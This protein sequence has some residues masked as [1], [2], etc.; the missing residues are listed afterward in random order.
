TIALTVII[1][2][3]VFNAFDVSKNGPDTSLN[4]MDRIYIRGL[5]AMVYY[6]YSDKEKFEEFDKVIS[7]SILVSYYNPYSNDT[8]DFEPAYINAEKNFDILKDVYFKYF[9]NHFGAVLR[10][11]LD[12]TNLLWSYTTPSDGF[13]YTYDLG[14]YYYKEKL[15]KKELGIS[16]NFKYSIYNGMYQRGDNPINS[17]VKAYRSTTG[18]S[19]FIESIFWRPAIALTIMLMVLISWIDRKKKLIISMVPTLANILFW[20]GFLYH[21]SYR[22]LWFIYVNT[23]LYILINIY[24]NSIRKGKNK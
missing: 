5:A 3:P 4:A 9:F 20:C 10:N 6:D 16:D 21:Q 13:N 18:Y 2:Y 7:R 12:G 14:V 8:F 17:T 22:Y 15:T 24:E 1:K 19:M 23:L 11:Q